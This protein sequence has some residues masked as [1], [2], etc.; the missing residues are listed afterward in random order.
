MYG[1][2]SY[3]DP[4]KVTL[5]MN[6]DPLLEPSNGPNYAPFDPEILYA[7]NI[8]N[9]H[10]AVADVSF[11]VRFKTEQR[12]AYQAFLPHFWAPARS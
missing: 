6:V 4:T 1:F 7:I 12:N 9:D 2:V 11:E 10:D 3:D 5:I 8:D